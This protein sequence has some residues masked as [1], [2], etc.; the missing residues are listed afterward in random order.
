MEFDWHIIT[1]DMDWAPDWMMQPWV[2]YLREA[3]VKA[4]WF[5][6]HSSPLV[7]EIEKD[8]L[9]EVG[10]HPNFLA[11]STHGETE[12]QV[13]Q[14]L[15]DWFPRAQA[16]RSH[17]LHHSERLLEK[18]T[19]EYGIQVDCSSFQQACS[20]LQPHQVYFA[21]EGARLVRLPHFFQDNMH[22]HLPERSWTFSDACFH[23]KGLKIFDFHPVHLIL[24][25]ADQSAYQ[26]FKAQYSLSEVT[27]EM[28]KVIEH[29]G[30]GGRSLFLELVEFLADKKTYTISQVAEIFKKQNV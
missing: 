22:C 24:N 19:A 29:K 16:V 15:S 27:P 9:F 14:Q 21:E 13:L 25:S 20:H 11:G 18:M 4:T 2:D 7:Q 5:A 17:S 26:R 8:P 10:I 6:T 12:D 3:Q 23:K 30:L 1:L 28:I